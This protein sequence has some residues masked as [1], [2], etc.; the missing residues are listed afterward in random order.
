MGYGGLWAKN[1]FIVTA[2]ARNYS[3]EALKSL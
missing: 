1:G 2:T 3:G